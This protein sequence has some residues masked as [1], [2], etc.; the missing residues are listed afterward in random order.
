MS[1]VQMKNIHKSFGKVVALQGVNFEVGS[2]EAVGLIGDNGAGKSTLIK[3]LSGVYPLTKGEI[4]IKGQKIDPNNYSVKKAHGLG[5]ET[6]FQE[7]ALGTKQTIWRNLFLG[8]EREL[9]KHLGFIQLDKA[10]RET[11]KMMKELLGFTGGGVLPDSRVKTLSGG[12][13]QGI[14]IGRAMYFK[15]DIVILDE[16]TRALSVKEVGKV[17]NFIKK[18]KDS[19]KSCVYI[20]HTIANVY[21]VSDRFVILDRGR[22]VGRYE[23]KEVSEPDLNEILIQIH[24]TPEPTS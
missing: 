5:I 23:R 14:A 16:P 9:T 10:K 3:I 13:R 17:L 4:Y 15:A 6:V 21:S 1:V 7:Q 19:G 12:E 20:S 18:L 11:D 2:N 22:V 8:R 24:Y